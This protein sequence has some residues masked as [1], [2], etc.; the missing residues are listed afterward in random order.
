VEADELVP[1]ACLGTTVYAQRMPVKPARFE[2][3]RISIA[4]SFAPSIS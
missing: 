2:K 3:L 1:I 4:H